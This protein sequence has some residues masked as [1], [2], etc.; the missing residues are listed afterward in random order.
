M[1]TNSTP[2]SG[3]SL[4]VIIPTYN[5]E[6]VIAVTVSQALSRGESSNRVPPEILVVDG[7]SSDNT[8]LAARAAGATRVLSISGG[9]AAQLNAGAAIARASTLFFLH[10][11]SIPPVDYPS[12]ITRTLALPRTIAGSFRLRIDSKV[13]ALRIVELVTNTRSRLFQIPYGDQGL[14][15][16]KSNFNAVGGYPDLTFMDDYA[17]SQKLSKSGRI[18][19]ANERVCT[20]ARRWELVGV[21]RT[22]ILNQC[23][24]LAYHL[25]VP[26]PTLARWYRGALKNALS[27]RKNEL[28]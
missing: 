2:H 10:A 12:H 21:V 20:S 22:S 24:V 18:R 16:T 23:I 14:F 19:I 5:E 4:S 11:D 13:W 27:K 7:G 15:L 3:P 1:T 17:M 28:L 9:R 8:I 26:V 6:A 25:G